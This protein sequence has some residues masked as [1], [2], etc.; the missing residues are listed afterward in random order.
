MQKIK[1]RQITRMTI[2]LHHHRIVIHALD[3]IR[4]TWKQ[5]KARSL[6]GQM[7]HVHTPQ[8]ARIKVSS[9]EQMCVGILHTD[10]SLGALCIFIRSI[11][12]LSDTG[13]AT[14][15]E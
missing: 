2:P 1:E 13:L 4:L 15:S 10:K 8:R 3:V 7:R 14:G 12:R 6:H 5:G 9:E 11:T